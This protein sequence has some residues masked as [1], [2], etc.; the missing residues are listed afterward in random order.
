MARNFF[1]FGRW[2]APHWFIGLEQGGGDNERRAEAFKELQRDGLCDCR[3]FHLRIGEP[4]WHGDGT[5]IQR[6]WGRLMRLLASFYGADSDDTGLLAYQKNHWGMHGGDT[7]IIELLGLSAAG[8]HVEM[9]RKKQYQMERIN[10]IREKLA[11]NT[12]KTVVM[13]GFTGE[14]SFQ[15]LAGGT[16]I[17]GEIV[18]HEKSLIIFVDHPTRQRRGNTDRSWNDLGTKMRTNADGCD[19]DPSL[20]GRVGRGFSGSFSGQE[21]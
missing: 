3:Q 12:P 2:S 16:L 11:E 7:C 15:K 4:R 1:G 18:K 17:R 6:T 8:L 21:N 20:I 13:Y 14:N 5:E 10:T 9:D 19:Y